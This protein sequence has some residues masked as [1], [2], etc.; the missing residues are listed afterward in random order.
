MK[1][2][3]AVCGKYIDPENK[4]LDIH[5]NCIQPYPKFDAV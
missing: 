4:Y 2:R 3:C 5:S 1:R